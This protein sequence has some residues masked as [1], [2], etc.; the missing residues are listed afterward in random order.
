VHASWQTA[1][2]AARSLGSHDDGAPQPSGRASN[3]ADPHPI[4]QP[5]TTARHR[6]SASPAPR[7]AAAPSTAQ[8]D[9]RV[10]PRPPSSAASRPA[11]VIVE[12]A[13]GIAMLLRSDHA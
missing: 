6:R 2:T 3:C 9:R 4:S 11:A 7:L 1:A 5:I 8:N 12:Q 13:R 10:P